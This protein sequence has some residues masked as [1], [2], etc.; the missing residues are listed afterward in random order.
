MLLVTAPGRPDSPATGPS[1][2]TALDPGLVEAV[3]IYHDKLIARTGGYNP[4]AI[5]VQYG[6]EPFCLALI[7]DAMRREGEAQA[8]VLSDFLEVMPLEWRYECIRETAIKSLDSKHPEVRQA[9]VQWCMRHTDLLPAD[10]V[11]KVKGELRRAFVRAPQQ[12]LWLMMRYPDKTDI[13]VIRE[14]YEK[15]YKDKDE[16]TPIAGR[17]RYSCLSFTAGSDMLE[18]LARLGEAKAIGEIEQAIRQL[19]DVERRTWGIW[20]AGKLKSQAL[21]F[22]VSEAL[23]D[24]RLCKEPIHFQAE[25]QVRGAWRKEFCRVCDVAVRA[26]QSISPPKRPWDFYVPGV[27]DGWL[28][29]DYVPGKFAYQKLLEVVQYSVTGGSRIEGR[30]VVGFSKEQITQVADHLKG[31]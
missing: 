3:R 31:K 20:L 29:G 26:I 8:R 10:L 22:A 5:V 12:V 24:E 17:S 14:V 28:P 21:L 7:Q 2:K 9:A 19:E 25:K 6:E 27:E 18:L 11:P 15:Q 30:F 1:S 4:R 23:G 16:W 13:P